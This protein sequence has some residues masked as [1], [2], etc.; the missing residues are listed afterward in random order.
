M[1]KL[2]VLRNKKDDAKKRAAKTTEKLNDLEKREQECE[3]ALEE[4]TEETTEEEKK[5]LEKTVDELIAEKEKLEKEKADIEAEIEKIDAEIE[6][7]E[8]KQERARKI[9]KEKREKER[10]INQMTTRGRF[11]GMT[12][13]Q[14]TAFVENENVKGFLE[15]VRELGKSAE[16]RGITGAELTIPIEVLDLVRENVENYSKLIKKVKLRSVSGTGRQPV[17]GSIPEAVWTEACAALN[18]LQFEISM[19]EVDGY[20]VGGFV[21]ICNATLED[22]DLNLAEEVINGIGQ[23]IG[24]ALDKAILYGTGIKMP[25]GIA[26]RLAQTSQ[27]DNYFTQARAWENLST[28]NVITISSD[29][30]GLEFFK[31]LVAASG[32]MKSKYSAGEKFWAMNEQT[33]TT[34][35]VEGMSTNMAGM[36][37]SAVEGTMP[38]VTGEIVVLS[39]EI[40]PDN[41]IIAG[42]GDLYLLAER[43]GGQFKRDDSYRFIED[44]AAFRG[45]ARYDGK[46]VI[47]EG[48]IAV[49]IGAAP[50]M[51]ATFAGD[52]ANDAR[53]D[54][55]VIGTETLSPVFDSNK[56]EYKLTTKGT[57]GSV[58]ATP[59][60]PGA[61]VEITYNDKTVVNGTEIKFGNGG[62]LNV[63]VKQGVAVLEYKV[64]IEKT[65]S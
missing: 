14:R 52:T 15:R 10:G 3:R 40:V 58:V 41:T 57:S 16:K 38:V 30:H 48:F 62:T 1:L 51:S 28:S 46:P 31:E 54:A 49:G 39:E 24:I 9:K 6:A 44:Q 13:E 33:Y 4:V 45:T 42:Y 2:I 12:A 60:Q 17:M 21:F 43:A 18:G 20:K 19:D 64:A 65:A 25:L 55:L 63:K 7:E 11:F 47:A 22:S 34:I 37:V 53:L 35:K 5:E 29:S 8:E 32:N 23:A 50:I 61:K 56:Y 36:I 59:S 26:T 27:P